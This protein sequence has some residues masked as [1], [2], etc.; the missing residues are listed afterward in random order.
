MGLAKHENFLFVVDSK[1]KCIHTIDLL[2]EYDV[3]VYPS[4]RN[5][6]DIF[7][8]PSGLTI[9]DRYLIMIDCGTKNKKLGPHLHIFDLQDANFPLVNSISLQG[10][11][12]IQNTNACSLSVKEESERSFYIISE[13]GASA[14]CYLEQTVGTEGAEGLR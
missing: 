1:D 14:T 10:V 3:T 13:D 12:D 8:S 5:D 6:L 7:A 9:V 4:M 11:I 2:S